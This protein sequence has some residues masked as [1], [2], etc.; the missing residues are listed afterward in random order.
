MYYYKRYIFLKRREKYIVGLARWLGL[1]CGRRWIHAT[2]SSHTHTRYLESRLFYIYVTELYVKLVMMKSS[3][4]DTDER[5]LWSICSVVYCWP[6]TWIIIDHHHGSSRFVKTHIS[7]YLI[8]WIIIMK[9]FFF[10]SFRCQRWDMGVFRWRVGFGLLYIL[11][12]ILS[13][14]STYM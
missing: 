10:F 12:I 9:S 13:P 4:V 1:L 2:A 5:I 14:D 6:L 11:V 3:F 7:Q 8:P